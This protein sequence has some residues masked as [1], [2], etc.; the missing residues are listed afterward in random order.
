[1]DTG[2]PVVVELIAGEN[3]TA[4]LVAD[5]DFDVVSDYAALIDAVDA[6]RVRELVL[7][8]GAVGKLAQ[9]KFLQCPQ[10][11]WPPVPDHL[12]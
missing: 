4:S 8:A 1:M 12:L 5:R 11:E 10:R 9:P 2:L 7:E 3:A 6:A